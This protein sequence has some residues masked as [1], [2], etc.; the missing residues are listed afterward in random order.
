VLVWLFWG[1]V[2]FCLYAYVGYPVLLILA[3]AV[4]RQSHKCDETCT[5]SLSIVMAA[6]NEAAVIQAKLDNLLSQDYPPDRLEIIVA[7]D[8]SDD[9]TEAIVTHY[10]EC[11][12]RVRLL[13]L[14]RRGK[15]HA[16][17]TAAA[18]AQGE[19]LV[20]SDANA[21]LDPGALRRLVRH[22]ANPR[23]GGVAGNLCYA[24]SRKTGGAGMGEVL[25][26]RYDQWLK[27][28]ETQ[29]GN[30][31]S[32]D[33]ALYAIRHALYVPI[34][35]PSTTDD[36]A[37]SSRVVV[38]GYRLIYEPRATVSEATAGSSSREFRR[39][40]RIINRGLRSLFGLGDFLYPWR[41]GFY[42]VQ[43]ISHKL[44]R[45][46]VPFALPLLLVA[47]AFLWPVSILYRIT[48]IAQIVFYGLGIIGFLLR[49]TPWGRLWPIY[50]PYYFCQANVAALVGVTGLLRG[51]RI[52]VWQPQREGV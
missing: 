19:I 41:G 52:A 2:A 16:L 32:A 7:S 25:Y 13:A 17:N 4:H 24:S 15:A 28:L 6:H 46:L 40:A 14:P 26:W 33:G 3:S 1:L 18:S 31:I 9:E 51:E 43:L 34:T 36:F 50:G 23:V 47:S 35:D 10:R 12:R 49:S 11:D 30:A 8:G 45:R 5:P 48:L 20:F 22:F 21:M 42:A 39:K 37:I 38:Q 29:V 44:L 27:Q